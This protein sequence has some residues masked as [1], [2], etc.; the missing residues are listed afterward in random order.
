MSRKLLRRQLPVQPLGSRSLCSLAA[1]F[2][3]V[4]RSPCLPPPHIAAK[5]PVGYDRPERSR[6]CA[7]PRRTRYARMPAHGRSGLRRGGTRAPGKGRAGRRSAMVRA[8]CFEGSSCRRAEPR[9]SRPLRTGPRA[10]NKTDFMRTL[11]DSL[12]PHTRHLPALRGPLRVSHKIVFCSLRP[13]GARDDNPQAPMPRGR[14]T[15]DVPPPL[16]I[17]PRQGPALLVGPPPAQPVQG[18]GTAAALR[19]TSPR[20]A[21]FEDKARAPRRRLGWRPPFDKLR[22]A[23][24]GAARRTAAAARIAACRRFMVK[25]T[26]QDRAGRAIST[27]PLS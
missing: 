25:T 24:S 15:G 13:H 20:R 4:G 3:P 19:G 17:G 1:V 9:P 2:A 27:P 21:V 7:P 12:A 8:G 6:P 18:F 26:R 16:A 23:A 11:A 14:G 5:C 22:A 10:E